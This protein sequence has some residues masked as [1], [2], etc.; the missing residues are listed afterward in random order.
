M[1][2]T[3][4][5]AI[6]S[7]VLFVLVGAIGT[8]AFAK[9]LK[10]RDEAAKAKYQQSWGQYQKEVNWYKNARQDFLNAKTKYQ[11]FKNAENKKA[12]EDAARNYLEKVVS[13][14]IKRLETIKN[15]VSNRGALPESE[16]QA[17]IAEI[18]Q[19]I[20]WLNEKLPKIQTA[21]P[22]QIK[23]EAKTVRQYWKTH[24]VRV[25]RII[26]EVWA[27]RINFVIGKA[28]SF[29]SE[30]SAKIDEL[31]AAGKDTSQ[32]EAWLADFNQKLALAKEKYAAA[33]AKF[34]EIKGEPGFDPMTEFNQANQL[35]KEGHQFIIQANQYIKEAHA[36]L[37]K[38]VKEMKKLG[39]TITS[40]EETPATETPT[41]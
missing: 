34:Q 14:L 1:K 13:S 36:Q 9:T 25:K 23:E 40:T 12:L 7:A 33:K 20:N 15:W 18:D 31:K 35:F 37:V 19:D 24:R 38:I 29:S 10:E 3:L 41:Q 32:L 6:L 30:V 21:S 26:G 11:Q 2:N 8:T 39:Q 22:D 28:E 27:A 16:K 17:I 5:I 4:K